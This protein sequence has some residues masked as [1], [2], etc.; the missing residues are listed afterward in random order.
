MRRV[1]QPRTSIQDI[2]GHPSQRAQL[3]ERVTVRVGALDAVHRDAGDEHRRRAG[4]GIKGIDAL[5]LLRKRLN[6]VDARGR[7][8]IAAGVVL[9]NRRDLYPGQKQI[10][11]KHRPAFHQD[12]LSTRPVQVDGNGQVREG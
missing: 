10:I 2:S 3:A 4:R 7:T 9:S 12:N 1:A 11:G 6:L 8:G 5:R